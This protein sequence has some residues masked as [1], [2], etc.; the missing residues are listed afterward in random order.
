MSE[1]TVEL[2]S[3]NRYQARYMKSS[4][5]ELCLLNVSSF[6]LFHPS[7]LLAKPLQILVWVQIW[8]SVLNQSNDTKLICNLPVPLNKESST[9]VFLYGE[10]SVPRALTKPLVVLDHIKLVLTYCWGGWPFTN[11]VHI[12]LLTVSGL[13]HRSIV[14]LHSSTFWWVPGVVNP[15][16]LKNG[17]RQDINKSS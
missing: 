13:F 7:F 8:L 16:V 2:V 1:T 10:A 5:F 17:H 15:H 11:I 9:P 4:T 6:L 3:F 12:V 14:C